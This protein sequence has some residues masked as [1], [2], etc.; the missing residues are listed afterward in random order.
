[1]T[2]HYITKRLGWNVINILHCIES[3]ITGLHGTACKWMNERFNLHSF[4][5]SFIYFPHLLTQ[6]SLT[7][8]GDPLD[9]TSMQ[10]WMER[11]GRRSSRWTRTTWVWKGSAR[12]GTSCRW[13]WWS[14]RRT[15][16][17][18]YVVSSVEYRMS[19]IEYRCSI[20]ICVEPKRNNIKTLLS[21]K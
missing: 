3:C 16:N 1:M 14:R 9:M 18:W 19:N 13:R 12:R 11:T 8:R 4:T 7:V 21:N 15:I 6:L 2:V 10:E 5:H 17:L 20:L